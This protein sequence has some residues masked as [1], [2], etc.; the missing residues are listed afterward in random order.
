[1]GPTGLSHS[2]NTS[3]T[4]D[5]RQQQR[6]QGRRY[7]AASGIIRSLLM[8]DRTRKPIA[9]PPCTAAGSQGQ[10]HE[11]AYPAACGIIRSCASAPIVPLGHRIAPYMHFYDC[12][13]GFSCDRATMPHCIMAEGF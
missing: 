7:E 10:R 12:T 9:G 4:S 1:M 11:A 13:R 8:H 6:S 3:C 2:L 5:S